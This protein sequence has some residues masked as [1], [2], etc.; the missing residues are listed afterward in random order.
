MI[1]APTRVLI[2]FRPTD[3]FSKKLCNAGTMA[4]LPPVPV[5]ANS[6]QPWSGFRMVPNFSA[7]SSSR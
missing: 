1:A 3:W 6:T 4:P 2:A 7:S 5:A